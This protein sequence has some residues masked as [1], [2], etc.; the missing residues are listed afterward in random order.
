MTIHV[1]SNFFTDD[2]GFESIACRCGWSAEGLPDSETAIDAFGEHCYEAGF[3][4]GQE[5]IRQDVRM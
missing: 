2:E 4:D 5:S 1:T 3:N